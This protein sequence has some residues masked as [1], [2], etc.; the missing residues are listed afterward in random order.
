[1]PHFG[2]M[3]ENELGPVEGPLQRARLHL[4]GGRRR[5]GQG[6]IAVG[7]GTLADALGAAMRWYVAAPRRKLALR[8]GEDLNDDRTVYAVLVRSGVLDGSFDYGA[9]DEVVD[10]ALQGE[11][12]GFDHRGLLRE[13]E[14]VMT[15]LGVMPFDE[16][17]L[18][19]EDPATF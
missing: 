10:R 8:D 12:P 1:M 7:I 18:P 11:V 16:S 15:Q 4:R 6:K 5:L 19:A 14:Q 13:L 17:S 9:F 3:D 2:L